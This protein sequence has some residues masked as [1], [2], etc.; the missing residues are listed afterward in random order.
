MK[1]TQC[2]LCGCTTSQSTSACFHCSACDFV[3]C[4]VYTSL[5][6]LEDGSYSASCLTSH[7]VAKAKTLEEAII[8]LHRLAWE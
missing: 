8:A 6:K 1:L 3:E 5:T 2:P 7:V 4:M